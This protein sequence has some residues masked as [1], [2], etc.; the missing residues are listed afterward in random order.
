MNVLS[1]WSECTIGFF[2]HFN[3]NCVIYNIESAQY[4]S[5]IDHTYP[6]IGNKDCTWQHNNSAS[7]SS[8]KH[9]LVGYIPL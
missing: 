5:L 6:R 7:G 3:N 2:S 9:K 1:K 8:R 4:G